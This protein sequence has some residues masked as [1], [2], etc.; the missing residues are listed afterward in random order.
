MSGIN[1]SFKAV[2]SNTKD[3]TAWLML[4][5]LLLDLRICHKQ[6]LGFEKPLVEHF[7]DDVI[8]AGLV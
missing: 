5:G 1:S 7:I 6:F 2:G 8:P 4:F 3:R